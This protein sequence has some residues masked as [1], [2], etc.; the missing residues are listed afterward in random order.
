MIRGKFSCL[1]IF[2]LLL[3]LTAL[4]SGCSERSLELQLRYDEIF[5]LTE[6]EAVYF[7]RNR[8]GQVEN[9]SYREMGDYLVTISIVPE[10]KNA[11]TEQ[12][13]FFIGADPTDDQKMAVIITQEQPGGKI[14]P[15]GSIV[16]GTVKEKYLEEIISDFRKKADE[17]QV[18]LHSTVEE[19]RKTFDAT[20]QKIDIELQDSIANLSTQLKKLEEE[21]GKIPERQ[22][23]KELQEKFRE[24]AD[25]FNR[26]QEDVRNYLRD[27]LL[28]KIRAELENLRERLE[29]S[30]REEELDDID[31]QL[32]EI[33]V[34]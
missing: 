29:K 12:S 16:E 8:I 7:E 4:V 20:S 9:V 23:V 19:L 2:A 26:A 27:T 22:E 5:G 11:A 10:F 28:P 15:E 17:M 33:T 32:D 13:K 25:Q 6:K 24:F 3:F 30:D 14:L 34:V 31:K 18:E 21:A 1:F